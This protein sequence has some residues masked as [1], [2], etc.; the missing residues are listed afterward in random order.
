MLHTP[1]PLSSDNVVGVVAA[2]VQDPEGEP[3][4]CQLLRC[5]GNTSDES[6]FDVDSEEEKGAPGG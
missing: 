2:G 6:D 5:G 3:M 4:W 1:T